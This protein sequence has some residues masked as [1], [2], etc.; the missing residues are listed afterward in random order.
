MPPPRTLDLTDANRVVGW[1]VG[2][3]V[4]F[5]GFANEAEAAHAAWVAYRTLSRRLARTHGIRPLPID[6]EA[7]A[8]EHRGH[9]EIVVSGSRPI[10]SLVRPGDDSR[11]GSDS[12]GFEIRVPA[13]A[14][15]LQVR[16]MAYL[17]YRTLRKSGI[18]WAL[19]QPAVKLAGSARLVST[20]RTAQEPNALS[21]VV[22]VVLAAVGIAL[23]ATLIVTAPRAV[24]IPLAIALGTGLVAS[25]LIKATDGYLERRRRT[26]RRRSVPSRETSRQLH[27]DAAA[28]AVG[29]G[30]LGALSVVL[31]VL[32][33][34]VPRELGIGMAAVGFAG[35]LVFRLSAMYGDWLPRS[36]ASNG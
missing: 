27:A 4:G 25:G 19:W 9:E 29:W 5:R 14:N 2:D 36:D 13:P 15:E 23:A 16:A 1:V 6:I 33:L 18:R 35:L 8:V 20:G 10:A 24:T 26:S 17:M 31:L 7:I 28:D 32:V 21:F 3:R 30:V 22:K 12:F 11:S 34:L